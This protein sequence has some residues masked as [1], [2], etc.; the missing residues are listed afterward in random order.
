M[1]RQITNKTHDDFIERWAMFVK[2]NPD[3]WKPIHTAFI[4]DQFRKSEEFYARL[5][6]TKDGKKKIIEIFGIK[7]LKG[8]PSLQ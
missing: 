8:Y 4:N 5:A 6:K 2:N 7:N 3:K 1:D